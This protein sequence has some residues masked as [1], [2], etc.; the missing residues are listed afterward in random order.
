MHL[1]Q[2][3]ELGLHGARPRRV[4]DDHDAHRPRVLDGAHVAHR[5]HDDGLFVGQVARHDERHRGP[6][7]EGRR[8]DLLQLA[9]ANAP[10]EDTAEDDLVRVRVKVRVRVRVRVGV[11]L[12]P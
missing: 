12:G 3:V 10:R 4:V 7:L 8:G 2:R 9:E 1:A 6:A 11:L 5:L